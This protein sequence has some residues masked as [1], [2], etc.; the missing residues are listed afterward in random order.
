MGQAVRKRSGG[1]DLFV[2]ICDEADAD[3]DDD[4]VNVMFGRVVDV[5]EK[6]SYI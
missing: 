4:V 2:V 3:D 5:S 6:F 1:N